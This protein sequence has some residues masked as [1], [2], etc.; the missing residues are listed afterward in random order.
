M[1]LRRGTSLLDLLP[2]TTALAGALPDFIV[3]RIGIL[4]VIDH[5]AMESDEA[6]FHHGTLQDASDAL[7]FD[8]RHWALRIPGLTTGLPFRLVAQRG[9][10]PS[11]ATQEQPYRGWVLDILV[12]DAEVE[13]PGLRQAQVAGG[14]GTNA[15]H[16]EPTG[17]TTPVAFAFSGVVRIRGGGPEG[18]EIQVI[19][20][21]D[22]FDPG[23]P[24]G[25]V[26]RL[27][28]R[29]PD[30]LIGSTEVGVSV[31][32]VL[33]DLSRTFTPGPVI[34]RGHGEDWE[35]VSL[36]RFGLYL[37]KSMPIF[38]SLSLTTKDVIVGLPFGVQGELAIE[39]GKQF[40]GMVLG[41]VEFRKA[42]TTEALAKSTK[43][44]TEL[45]VTLPAGATDAIPALIDVVFS[46]PTNPAVDQEPVGA[47]WSL[48]TGRQGGIV[49]LPA[50]VQGVS[51]RV[52][53]VFTFKIQ[54]R[55]INQPNG[56]ISSLSTVTVRFVEG[57]NPPGE[58]ASKI[59]VV[60]R[61]QTFKNVAEVRGTTTNLEGIKFQTDPRDDA[62]KWSLKGGGIDRTGDTWDFQPTLPII[63][64]SP[65]STFVVL[66]SHGHTRRLRLS[67]LSE[68]SVLIGH[69]AQGD[70]TGT[71][72][73]LLP[74]PAPV[75]VERVKGTYDLKKFHADGDAQTPVQPAAAIVLSQGSVDV[76]VPQG[77]LAE[78]EVSGGTSDTGGSVSI[79]QGLRRGIALFFPFGKGDVP[80]GAQTIDENAPAVG[81][82]PA[83]AY[84]LVQA[85]G[86]KD[87]GW[88]VVLDQWVGALPS[89]APAGRQFLILGRTDDLW[90]I[91]TDLNVNA[92]RNQELAET[93]ANTAEQLLRAR[94]L[95]ATIKA[96][97]Q[98][99]GNLPNTGVPRLTEGRLALPPG[100]ET[101]LSA[102]DSPYYNENW[103]ADGSGN[104]SNLHPGARDDQHRG[105]Y[106]SVEI[107]AFDP[108]QTAP[109]P[110]NPGDKKAIPLLVPGQDGARQE[111]PGST[112]DSSPPINFRIRLRA[113]WDS[114]TVVGPGDWFPTLLEALADFETAPVTLPGT[115]PGNPQTATPVTTRSFWELIA[116]LTHDARTGSTELSGSLALPE[117]TMRYENDVLV[118]ALAF[119]P[120]LG[121]LVNKATGTSEDG[122]GMQFLK[123]AALIGAGIAIAELI[124]PNGPPGQVD[125]ERFE[126]KYRWDSASF[127]QATA[128][129]VC[130]VRM[131]IQ[132]LGL[133]GQSFKIRYK[134]VGLRFET[135]GALG[136]EGISLVYDRVSVEVQDAGTWKINGTLGELLRVAS[137][138]LG[139]GSVWIELELEFALDLGVIRLDGAK[140]RVTV[141]PDF[142]AELR[143]LTASVDIPGVLAGSG[144]VTVGDGGEL[145]AL[146][147]VNVIPAKLSAYGALALDPPLAM[148]EV[149]VRFPVGIPLASTGLALWGLMG[150]FVAN[151]KR[152]ISSNPAIDPVQRELIWFSETPPQNKYLKQQGQYAVGF[153][154][155]I[156]TM[157]DASFC[158][159]AEGALCVEF[160]DIAVIF[161]VT[162]KGFTQ[163]EEVSEGGDGPPNQSF[164]VTGMTVIDG[165]GVKI[166]LRGTYKIE[167][168]LELFVPVSASFPTGGGQPWYIR[169]G[170]DN[171]VPPPDK[172][173]SRA[174]E[175]VKMTLFP[176]TLS[177][178]GNGFLM[179]EQRGIFGLGK[180]DSGVNLEGF[181]IGFGAGFVIDWS[182]GPFRMTAGVDF[183][184]GVGTRP[185]MLAGSMTVHGELSLVVVSVTVN[186]SLRFRIQDEG[187]FFE[188][189]FC[190]GV[191][192]WLFSIEGCVDITFINTIPNT[193]PKPESPITG[194]DLCDHR[195]AIKGSLTANGTGDLPV[196]WPDTLPVVHFGHSVQDGVR[197]VAS[198][199]FKIRIEEA[200]AGPWSGSSELKYAFRLESVDI[201]KL[202]SGGNPANDAD[203]SRLL[204]PFDAAWWFPTARESLI[205]TGASSTPPSSEEG[206]DL[207]LFWWHPF[208][209]ARWLNE[210]GGEGL[211]ADPTTPWKT[212]CD[213]SPPVTAA[214]AFGVDAQPIE[215]LRA[216]V[217]SRPQVG[218]AFPTE[219]TAAI[220]VDRSLP[221]FLLFAFANQVGI[222]IGAPAVVPLSR[223]LV[224]DGITFTEAWQLATFTRQG[225]FLLSLPT[226]L[227][228][229]PGLVTPALTME[230][231]A[232]AGRDTG[233][234]D[235]GLGSD[236]RT[237]ETFDAV[238]AARV[239]QLLPTASGTLIVPEL[240]T[241]TITSFNDGG[242]VG[243]VVPAHGLHFD[244]P[245]TF[246]E[247]SVTG[248]AGPGLTLQALDS[249]GTIVDIDTI[250]GPG[251]HTVTLTG[252]TIA[253]VRV[254]PAAVG[255]GGGGPGTGGPGGG[256]PGGGLTGSSSTSGG[257]AGD[258]CCR[259]SPTPG[260]TTPGGLTG[261]PPTPGIPGTP[262]SPGSTGGGPG[263]IVEICRLTAGL[264]VSIDPGVLVPPLGR[265]LPVVVGVLPSGQE[266]E[267]PATIIDVPPGQTPC[268]HVSYQ[269][270]D[271][272]TAWSLIRIKAFDLG[273]IKVVSLCGVSQEAIDRRAADQAVRDSIVSTTT[274]VSGTGV[275]APRDRRVSLDAGSSY[276]L[277]VHW[278][279]QGWKPANT[280]QKPPALAATWLEG[281]TERFTFRTAD[282]GTT[283]PATGDGLGANPAD[284]GPGYDERIFDA[285]GLARFLVHSQPGDVIGAPFFVGD[286][287]VFRFMVDHIVELLSKYAA[288]SLKVRVLRTDP[289]LATLDGVPPHQPG[290]PHVLDVATGTTET[291]DP[292]PTFPAETRVSDAVTTPPS[293]CMPAPPRFGGS[294][295]TVTA[296]LDRAASYDLELFVLRSNEEI[297]VARSQFRTSRY[298][299]V[300]EIVDALGF[301]V[302]TAAFTP[303]PDFILDGAM[304]SLSAGVG[305]G[306]MDAALRDLGMDPWP[307]PTQP[308]CTLIWQP[309]TAQGAPWI[310]S[311]ALLEAEEPLFREP[312]PE[313]AFAFRANAKPRMTLTSLTAVTLDTNDQPIGTAFTLTQTIR[314]ASGTR[315]LFFASAPVPLP[316]GGLYRLELAAAEP[317]GVV[318]KGSAPVF[319]RPLALMLEDQ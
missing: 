309:P 120:S 25:A 257:G 314:N 277:R 206:R 296:N 188:G 150:R 281:A 278:K 220:A 207:G 65:M 305:D 180:A 306:L 45:E 144:S 137:A 241:E 270:P 287:V 91:A 105:P 198:A 90:Q 209:W 46:K 93:R 204:G 73:K 293:P 100:S 57:A 212:A 124:N 157:P 23:A 56:D 3:D 134:N 141:L 55:K 92:T 166:G 162:A 304:P 6:F 284:G 247:V 308:R 147:S 15:L 225:R 234:R 88:E 39:W 42:N 79:K 98:T 193:I 149:G 64:K 248:F 117:G 132:S 177:M 151:G 313:H 70:A 195:A 295:I 181:A 74:N 299:D 186:G 104:N 67:L 187:T 265:Q 310:L 211:P 40:Q 51:A 121:A 8:T 53:D 221:P 80:I 184:V 154:A 10:A 298:L 52:G 275:N 288:A 7:G 289:P 16:L 63:G 252:T 24:A 41:G 190:G 44:A 146:L 176:G 216:L 223:S 14:Q 302:D 173:P 232:E 78:V 228:V 199:P 85:F 174:G 269:A 49:T 31:E 254:V 21:P 123:S 266:V 112:T 172:G 301:G 82:H 38:N 116:R 238:Q 61:N 140:V 231:C 37:P 99:I 119:A 110:F 191:D 72:S 285:R 86:E 158:F 75:V 263:R 213:P 292:T 59:D 267:F 127:L 235:I 224:V 259:V 148:V 13:I 115:P 297:T 230:V 113:K 58:P 20:H 178:E 169:I 316:A 245:G 311:G 95:N 179:I 125:I 229:T 264:G 97:E 17:A 261:G 253:R 255:P 114:P 240:P 201:Y 286:P 307:V 108:G 32:D 242:Q 168:V 279:Y 194:V 2:Q 136:I 27:N 29:P 12:E 222:A 214:C 26:I 262:G 315:I 89:P 19:D 153:G 291:V 239:A 161:G 319:D 282:W 81:G 192:C 251:S 258:C 122:T 167:K 318:T 236:T 143:G 62:A 249:A 268:Q 290:T 152:N 135:D 145:R 87:S 35:G 218:A 233:P 208:P 47:D 303:P 101:T 185:L 260:S 202:N 219:F 118:G 189:H 182:T 203:W 171:V 210:T 83:A 76:P 170:T 200:A 36:K 256:L 250:Q 159:S 217:S 94:G 175:R 66:E 273:S 48:S 237:C 128:D 4:T 130:I 111:R 243:L 133:T 139:T 22:P 33:V 68:A 246:K 60:L 183:V 18:T 272:I 5:R 84:P 205:T 129:Y 11:G 294:T 142:D 215:A 28:V 271:T 165:S 96:T 227:D 69:R 30:F 106:R 77:L 131:N 43:S 155:V 54:I 163:K 226:E 317:G 283:A 196:V 164:S 50:T 156:G 103:S 71:V 274:S 9:Q 160:P 126:L 300:E 244:L 107:F 197:G 276:Q 109:P 34:A 312:L 280:G 1:S 102:G 138:R